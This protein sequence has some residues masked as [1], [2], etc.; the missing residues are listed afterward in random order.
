MKIITCA[1]EKGGVGKTTVATHVAMGLARRG[2]R[3]VLIDSDSQGNATERVGVR[4]SAGLY[5]L[6]VRDAAWADVTKMVDPAKYGIPGEA[7]PDARLWVLPSNVETRNIANSVSDATLLAQRLDEL[8]GAVDVVVID[9]SPT[10]S[11]LHGSIYLATD[12]IIY[13]TTCT[14]DSFRGLGMSIQHRAGADD[15]RRQ[16]L[17]MPGVKI[18]GI[19][20]TLY[21]VGTVEQEANLKALR[22]KFAGL[23]WPQMNLRTVWTETE[24]QRCA[25]WTL[26]AGSAAAG[27]AWELIDRIEN[28]L[29]GDNDAQ[30]A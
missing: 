12:Y 29:E 20:P 11:L 14:I 8:R 27:D 13:P 17:Q 26:D 25:V 18:M 23:V 5:D 24:S 30:T 10:P 21:R 1:N 3:V 19:V 28:V 7:V 4:M 16:R 9:T 2:K 15:V 6:I 22:D